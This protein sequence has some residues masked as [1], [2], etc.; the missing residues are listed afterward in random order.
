MKDEIASK[1][2]IA[3]LDKLLIKESSR[4]FTQVKWYKKIIEGEI[5]VADTA[6]TLKVTSNKRSIIYK[7]GIFNA[8]K[9]YNY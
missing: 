9:P 8:T 6:Y 2:H 3:D 1:L 7:N 4:E 5:P